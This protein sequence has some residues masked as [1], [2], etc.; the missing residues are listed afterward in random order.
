MHNIRYSGNALFEIF[1]FLLVFFISLRMFDGNGTGWKHIVNSDGR[2]YYAYLPSLILCGDPTFRKGVEME[3][4]FLG[5]PDYKPSYIVNVDGHPVNKYFSGEALLLLPFF[6]LGLLLSFLSGVPADGYNFCFQVS[7]GLG[8][9]FYAMAGL[10]FLSKILLHFRIRPAIASVLLPAILLGTNLL[11]YTIW[12]PTMS[13]LYS[14][15]AINGLIFYALAAIK[16]W[17]LRSALPTGLFL[18][19]VILIR[20]TNVLVLLLLPFLAGDMATFTAFFKSLWQ[21]KSV[22]MLFFL[23]LFV[24]VSIQPFLWFLQTGK[25]FIWSYDNEGFLFSRPEISN[26][27]FSF[28]KGL[29]IYTPL[30]LLSWSGLAFLAFTS[31]TR[32]F[33]MLFFIA[34]STYTISIWW[35]WYYGDSFGLRAFIDYY[36]IYCL[37]LAVAINAL[38]GKHALPVVM[39]IILPLVFLNLFQTWQY[40]H[41]IIQPNSMNRAKYCFI[42]MRADSAHIN[43]LGGNLELPEFTVDRDKP[44]LVLQNDFESAPNYW[45]NISFRQSPRSYSPCHAGYLDSLNQFGP[46]L[47]LPADQLGK[48]PSRFFVEGEVMVWDSAIGASN[49]ALVVLSMDS[50]NLRKS[51]WQGFRLNDIPEKKMKYWR[52]CRFSLTLPEIVNRNGILKIYI[53][54]PGRKPILIDDFKLSFYRVMDR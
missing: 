42:F 7:I 54:N 8:A 50:I 21:R 33:S 29:F 37:L 32:F 27:L 49:A 47:V 19:I 38:P 17:N 36:G 2:G 35:N 10:I 52:K 26:V 46:G 1:C 3:S 45:N 40:T 5:I 25:M 20:P 12:Q 30:I 41:N 18:G 22:S 13:H 16:T 23:V 51:Y 11:Y 34:I 48:L 39:A 6:L 31:R 4:R 24:L 44:T 9:L 14:F 53:W 15:F 43:G 28:R